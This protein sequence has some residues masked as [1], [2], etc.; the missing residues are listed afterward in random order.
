MFRENVKPNPKKRTINT[1][2]LIHNKNARIF[3]AQ[4]KI[5]K[6]NNRPHSKNLFIQK[7]N[8]DK[9]NNKNK[10]PIQ[11]K[12]I[13]NLININ[14]I[15]NIKVT[16]PKKNKSK[17]FYI[18]NNNHNKN[19]ENNIL[20]LN[21]NNLNKNINNNLIV[22][23]NII[24]NKNN[25]NELSK[26]LKRNNNPQ[27]NQIKF[28]NLIEENEKKHNKIILHKKDNVEKNNNINLIN[29]IHRQFPLIKNNSKQ[30]IKFLEEENFKPNN[31]ININNNINNNN[32][33]QIKFLNIKKEFDIKRNIH[34]NKNKVNGFINNNFKNQKKKVFVGF[35]DKKNKNN[36]INLKINMKINNNGLN[37]NK[38]YF[39]KNNNDIN[40]NLKN[41]EK[42]KK[43]DRQNNFLINKG[44]D[45]IIF[46]NNIK[47]NIIRLEN[48][49]NKVKNRFK[50]NLIEK[51][52]IIFKRQIISADEG[53]IIKNENK[54]IFL[55]QAK[56][57]NNKININENKFNNLKVIKPKQNN[58]SNSK[59]ID[60]CFKENINSQ[61]NETMEDF[62]LIKH[63]FFSLGQNNLSIF[64]VF[65]GHG[66]EDVAKFLKN[67]FCENLEKTIK[68]NLTSGLT[69]ILKLSIENI[70]K[71]IEKIENSKNS[72]S[73]GTF[74]VV[75]NNYI[76]CAN[77][78]DSKGFYINENEAIQLTEDH[79]CKNEK[80]VAMLK[81]KGVMIFK[82]RV[83]GSLSLTRSFGDMVYKVD[84]INCEPFIKKI[85]VDKQNVK[86][87]VI[88]SDG[89]WDI[90][91]GKILYKISKELKNGTC[92][93]F[94]DNLVN[95]AL[96]NGS[97]DNISCVIIKFS[98]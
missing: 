41:R 68:S 57:I 45:N 9:N 54:K 56:I 61:F 55:R 12:N 32:N 84:G 4:N 78:G 97:R 39:L 44:N 58:E 10:L 59:I 16:N 8:N 37:N 33:N 30:K 67:N 25:V 28:F 6:N 1:P 93:E 82:Q 88:A 60:F 87:V 13:N 35:E 66:G 52:N 72:G 43:N 85:F 86:Y 77:V 92:E 89:I 29:N 90:V 49:E 95:Y 27:N 47:N 73:T 63:P 75:N 50:N 94:C 42:K 83:F 91:D 98:H 31:N 24:L 17:D 65:D 79:N 34:I 22:N 76:Y 74:I 20:N 80:E 36:L 46:A 51:N 18:L 71:N 14:N 11:M 40:M 96:E 62:T 15:N 38:R 70:D 53:P 3:L 64:A 21:H 69:E 5:P 23:N 26:S 48:S 2:G 81:K 19:K 7:A